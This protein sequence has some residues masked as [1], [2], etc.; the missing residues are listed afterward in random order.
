MKILITF[1]LS[2]TFIYAYSLEKN[3]SYDSPIL[4]ASDFFPEIKDDFEVISMPSHLQ[5]F[6]ISQ[7]RLFE[8]F[9]RHNI[10]LE[11]H[12]VGV[13]K[14]ERFSD[15]SLAPL[16]EKVKEY[17]LSHLPFLNIKGI[18]I[19]STRHIDTLPQNYT[20]VFKKQLY[21]QSKG[22][23]KLVSKQDRIFFNVTI[24]ASYQQV[25]VTKTMSKGTLLTSDNT[26]LVKIPFTRTHDPLLQ[27]NI[28]SQME[29][30]RYLRKGKLLT[31]KD[32]KRLSMVKKGAMVNVKLI[33]GN[34]LIHFTATALKSG[35]LNETIFIKKDDG[36]KLRA[37]II[38]K[39]EVSIE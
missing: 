6:Q 33:E 1:L 22:T 32:V 28:L 37:K 18:K 2:F 5:H 23:F 13:V 26:S 4:F 14:F 20:L 25:Q 9:S 7:T 35:N 24:D 8:L 39:D 3:Y 27:T 38:A 36:T 11:G 21:K 29:S 31:L 10:K 19:H 15:L 34:I 16:E 17:Y 30:K 12:A